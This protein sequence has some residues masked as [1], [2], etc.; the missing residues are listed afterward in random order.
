MRYKWSVYGL[1]LSFYL[2][3]ANFQMKLRTEQPPGFHGV[4]FV[5]RRKE[6]PMYLELLRS[7]SA[8]MPTCR[9]ST[10]EKSECVCVTCLSAGPLSPP[11]EGSLPCYL[12]G[13]R[14]QLGTSSL[15]PRL[16]IELCQERRDE[17]NR[18]K[19]VP[20]ISPQFN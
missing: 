13:G 18:G 9:C 10:V 15:L 14:R 11:D 17:N 8:K 12:R 7:S 5:G 4:C 2:S 1:S 3:L 6:K 16:E 19:Y 20:P